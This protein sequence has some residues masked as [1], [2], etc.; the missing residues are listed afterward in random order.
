MVRRLRADR[1][2]C[3]GSFCDGRV[4]RDRRGAW[5][6]HAEILPTTQP[7]EELNSSYLVQSASRE[8]VE[9]RPRRR[10]T[11]RAE[12]KVPG[13]GNG[14]GTKCGSL[15]RSPLG[16]DRVRGRRTTNCVRGA[17]YRGRRAMGGGVRSY[18]V[19]RICRREDRRCATGPP[20]RF[21]RPA[22][23]PARCGARSSGRSRP[24][25]SA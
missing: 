3:G 14:A 19:Q 9:R 24:R 18:A 11:S 4:S 16:L 13:P 5:I 1:C 15:P 2:V 20:A 12:Y 7:G 21:K 25:C 8:I 6:S 17:E 22:S 10:E 23:P